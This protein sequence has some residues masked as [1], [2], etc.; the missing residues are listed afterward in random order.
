MARTVSQRLDA[1]ETTM[2]G[3]LLMVTQIFQHTF[4]GKPILGG[5]P[6]PLAAE[7]STSTPLTSTVIEVGGS[8]DD[9]D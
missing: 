6:P 8:D 2:H 5:P 3:L 1:L 4:S 9:D 7:R